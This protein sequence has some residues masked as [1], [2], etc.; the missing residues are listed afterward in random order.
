[1]SKSVAKFSHTAGSVPANAKIT[2]FRRSP[3]IPHV[4][5]FVG[6]PTWRLAKGDTDSKPQFTLATERI[7]SGL[8]VSYASWENHIKAWAFSIVKLVR[9]GLKLSKAFR[10]YFSGG[11]STRVLISR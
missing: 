1:M 9:F 8:P 10:S 3:I 5:K 4:S 11:S 2:A 7:V 6:M